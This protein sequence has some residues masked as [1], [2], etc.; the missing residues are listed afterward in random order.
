VGAV[1]KSSHPMNVRGVPDGRIYMP[2]HLD[3]A[4]IPG[5]VVAIPSDG[6]DRSD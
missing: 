5:V 3:D 4:T 6:A 2:P 1:N